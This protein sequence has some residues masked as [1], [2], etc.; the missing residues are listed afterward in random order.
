[1]SALY[2]PGLHLI[3]AGVCPAGA[4][5]ATACTFCQYG[6]MTE[7]HHP[8]TCEEA[9]CSH[10]VADEELIDVTDDYDAAVSR[11]EQ[12]LEGEEMDAREAARQAR[13]AAGVEHACASCGCSE[14]RACPGGCVWAGPTLCSRC[15]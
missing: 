4:V 9:E 8:L 1:M 13:I 10:Y 7:C 2:L 14:T 15:V 5:L 3:E 6:H 11:A 12:I